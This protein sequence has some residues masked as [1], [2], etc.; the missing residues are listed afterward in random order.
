MALEP[1]GWVKDQIKTGIAFPSFTAQLLQDSN[2]ELTSDSELED[3]VLW[4]AGALYAAGTDTTVSVMKN[5]FFCMMLYPDVQ[6]RGQEEVDRFM[7]EEN[8]LPSLKDWSR[9]A[10]PFVTSIV[11]EV[12]RWHPAAPLG[13]PHATT[14]EDMYEGYYIPKKVTIIGNIWAMLHDESVYPQPDT[15][16]PD[17]YSGK[18]G[19][20]IEDD[21]RSIVFGFGRRICPG[22]YIAEASIWIQIATAL[23]CLQIDKPDGEKPEVAFTSGPPQT[24]FMQDQ[25]K[26]RESRRMDEVGDTGE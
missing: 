4:S 6:S 5:F 1:H 11:Q 18:G 12:L 16:D 21:P 25:R 24:L 26:E 15:F 3:I 9:G 7:H 10:L 20:K 23:A 2:G 8:R 13:I 22:R 17:R 19:R 14:H